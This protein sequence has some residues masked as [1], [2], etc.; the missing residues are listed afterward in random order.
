MIPICRGGVRDLAF[1]DTKD[2]A[3]EASLSGEAPGK[4]LGASSALVHKK[5][6]SLVT[7]RNVAGAS[8]SLDVQLA[9][10][11]LTVPLP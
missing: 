5:F 6:P 3:F 1:A 7:Q 2:P 11:D 10:V 4:G 8:S 9:N